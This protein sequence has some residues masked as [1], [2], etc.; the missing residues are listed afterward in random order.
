MLHKFQQFGLRKQHWKQPFSSSKTGRPS[1][2][3][4]STREPL[5]AELDTHTLFGEVVFN[6]SMCG[7]QQILTDPSYHGKMVVIE[8]NPRVPRSSA[9]ASKATGFPIVRCSAKLAVGY[10]LDEII[11]EITGSS[12]SCFE[13]ALDY[14]VVKEAVFSFDRFSYVDPALGPVMRSTRESIGLEKSFGEAL[15]PMPV[16]MRSGVWWC[17]LRSPIPRQ[18]VPL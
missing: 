1:Q 9:L 2:A 10:T 8:M 17:S 15:A 5:Y 13:P 18:P 12:V 11:N 6:T 4:G 7:Y 3:N 16:M 14:C